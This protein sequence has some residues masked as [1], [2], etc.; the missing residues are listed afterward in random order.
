MIIKKVALYLRKS[1]KEEGSETREQTLARHKRMLKDYCQR[2]NLQIVKVYEEVVSAENLEAR[3]EALQMLDD[4]ADGQFDGVVVI[5]LERLSRGNQIDQVEILETFKKSKTLIY[6]LN[7]V[8]DLSSENELDEEFFEFGLYMSRREY[9]TIKRRLMRGKKQAQKE[10][11]Y[12]GSSLP[13]GFN[14]IRGDKGYILVPNDETKI[15]QMIFNKYVYE[16]CSLGDIRRYL[17]NNG[18]KP[19]R[20]Q[21]WTTGSIK[22]LMRNKTY[23]GFIATNTKNGKGKEYF[24]GKHEAIIDIE[25]FEKAQEKLKIHSHKT[26]MDVNLS[27]ALASL[28]KC[29]VCGS[30]MQK[31]TNSI[32]CVDPYCKTTSSYYEVVEKKVIEEIATELEN[33]NCFLENY[34]EQIEKQKKITKL[35][36]DVLVKSIDKKRKMI[37]KAC[38]MLEMG[39]YSTDKYLSRVNTLESEINAIQ[40][41]ITALKQVDNSKTER[42]RRAIP[43]LKKCLDDYWSLS[44]EEKNAVL[45]TFIQKI[46]YTKT[47]K[48]NRFDGVENVQLKI[49]LEI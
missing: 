30:T 6:T 9:K 26:K 39:V 10:G 12:I 15:V 18:I 29:S 17:N 21:Y 48:N 3:P 27:N 28:I 37:D 47:K 16:N 35:E 4:V 23:S 38:E 44:V 1:R 46:E 43:I 5:E 11:Y 22:S 32:R 33:F 49:F 19:Q 7:K 42:I 45:K 41:Q 2:N 8:Y 25:T 34:G 14:K 31:I 36:L 13:Y 40:E 24:K 20:I